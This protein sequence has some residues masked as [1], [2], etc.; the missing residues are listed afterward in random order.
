VNPYLYTM[1]DISELD[2]EGLS[3]TYILFSGREHVG[4][5]RIPKKRSQDSDPYK[6]AMSCPL[7]QVQ[8]ADDIKDHRNKRRPSRYRS[9]DSNRHKPAVSSS[10][11]QIQKADNIRKVPRSHNMEGTAN[12]TQQFMERPSV[13]QRL[14]L[15]VYAKNY[16]RRDFSKIRS[17][18]SAPYK[19]AVSSRL[20]QVHNV[21]DAWES[22]PS[23]QLTQ[24]EL[25][26]P[27]TPK[28]K[29][30]E[31]THNLIE[32][33]VSIRQDSVSELQRLTWVSR[34]LTSH[35]RGSDQVRDTKYP[36]N[37]SLL[38]RF[39]TVLR[40]TIRDFEQTIL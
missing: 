23:A 28:P 17:P 20:C 1:P 11:R 26:A 24:E 21:D 15:K 38:R 35:P 3:A 13:A 40:R 27:R 4:K 36:A 19:P 25:A 39:N 5:R 7:H 37:A 31:L 16:C 6:P 30:R 2:V 34:H 14:L 12:I 9:R 33:P 8:N 22:S 18:G 32:L 10:P 29:F